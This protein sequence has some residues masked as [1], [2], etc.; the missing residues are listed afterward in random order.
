MHTLI[1]DLPGDIIMP[2]CVRC[3]AFTDNKPEGKYHYCDDCLDYFAEIESSGVIVEQSE[4]GGKYHV[5]VTDREASL[6]GGEEL[7]QP[8]ALARGKYIADECNLPALFKYKQTG[9]TWV[10][11]EYL[12]AHPGIRGD[13]HDRLRRVPEQTS[14]GFL[15]RIR[16]FL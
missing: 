15:D 14:E 13:V 2:E 3:G 4:Q 5:I 9:S 12:K 8:E 16:Q 7:S 11:E 1:A 6:D 10:L